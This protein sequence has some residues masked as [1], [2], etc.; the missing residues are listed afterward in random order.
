VTNIIQEKKS[1]TLRTI[2]AFIVVLVVVVATTI[3]IVI[4]TVVTTVSCVPQYAVYTLINIVD[5]FKL[6]SSGSA[7]AAYFNQFKPADTA[8]RKQ[9][10]KLIVQIGKQRQQVDPTKITD[11]LIAVA[12]GTAIQESGMRNLPYGDLDSLGIFQQ[13]PSVMKYGTQVPFWGTAEQV[14]NPSYSI[15]RFYDALMV[16][17]NVDSLSMMDIAIQI[18]GPSVSA[19]RANW[20]WDDIANDIVHESD[21]GEKTNVCASQNV[22]STSFVS[23]TGWGLPLAPGYKAGDGYGPRIDPISG[24]SG[25]H[26]GQDL[27]G[28]PKGVPIYAV[29]DGTVTIASWTG[30]YGNFVRI[31]NGGGVSS[32]Y[33]HLSGYQSGLSPGDIVKEG[34]VLGFVGSTGHSTGTHLH[35]EISV[36]G[37]AVDPVQFMTE[38]GVHLLP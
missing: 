12:I 6:L 13:R 24:Q 1:S 32:S 23:S 5:P 28:V 20:K 31:N 25:F 2:V 33:G 4:T 3:V 10:A 26:H 15:N 27:N 21:Q 14:S 7:A 36:N 11:K 38:H 18:Q 29:H 17:R 34:Q 37:V 19:Y 9:I 35:L 16:A 8:K 30:G 22:A